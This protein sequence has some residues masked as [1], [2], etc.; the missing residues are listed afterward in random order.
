MVEY[1]QVFVDCRHYTTST[2]A[3][4]A[5]TTTT[6]NNNNNN[7]YKYC[8]MTTKFRALPFSVFAPPDIR[9]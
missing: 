3:A 4:A 9:V 2:A 5:I 6:N 1:L 7:T 8:G